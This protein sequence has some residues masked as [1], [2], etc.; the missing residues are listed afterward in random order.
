VLFAWSGSLLVK[1][2]T[3]GKGVLNQHVFKVSSKQYPKWFYYLWTS[4]YLSAFQRIAAD[5]ATTMGHIKRHHLSEA[6]ACIPQNDLI[7]VMDRVL[8][9]ILEQQKVNSLQSSTLSMIRDALLP[10]LLSGEIQVNRYLR[11]LQ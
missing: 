3:G 7:M 2:W 4:H 11:T 5:K 6:K 8:S 1:V 9:P 10:R